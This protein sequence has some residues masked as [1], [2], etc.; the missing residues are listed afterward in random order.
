MLGTGREGG[1]GCEEVHESEIQDAPNDE[2]GEDEVELVETEIGASGHV[3]E[4]AGADTN[5]L[6]H[7]NLERELRV[8]R[9]P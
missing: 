8:S 9:N 7:Q 4:D 5:Q 2:C 6:L 3:A 1:G